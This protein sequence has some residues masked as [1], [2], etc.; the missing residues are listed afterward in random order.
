M[1]DPFPTDIAA[2][3]RLR[4][5]TAARLAGVPVATLRVWERRYGVVAAP[6]TATG[7]RLYSGHDVQRL[8][9]IKQLTE[10]GHAI[11]TIAALALPALEALAAGEL[12]AT[13]P[14]A[15]A[16]NTRRTWVVGRAAAQKL[17]A[18]GVTPLRVWQDLDE[19]EAQAE[20][21]ATGDAADVLLVQLNSLQPLAASR[22][23]A[24]VQR[25]QAKA[26]VVLYAF[27]AQAV[28]DALRAAGAAV[29]REPATG[30]ELAALLG[31]TPAATLA[32]PVAAP[33]P[34]VEPR[35]FS[36]ESLAALAELP[37]SVACE[38]PRHMAEIVMQLA[39]FERYSAEC[40]S[41]SPADAALHRHL[42]EVAGAAR[43]L[44]ERAVERLVAEEGLV[45]TPSAAPAAV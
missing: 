34:P 8:R 18:A 19:A 36:D 12:M 7:Q 24:L 39:G 15:A 31:A 38:C 25:L 13:A 29:R 11:G 20:S 4:S 1:T 21:L 14:L 9:L 28:A 2:T 40:L 43:T 44:F 26:V 16:T 5:G 32:A 45:L 17:Q 41:R 35:R 10:R 42:G 3:A 23:R 33:L 6:K 37:S 30:R 27:G 22:V